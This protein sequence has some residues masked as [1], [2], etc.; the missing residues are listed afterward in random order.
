[1]F[2]S[3]VNEYCDAKDELWTRSSIRPDC[4]KLTTT[5]KGYPLLPRHSS[6]LLRLHF[7]E[8]FTH[9]PRISILIDTC[10]SDALPVCKIAEHRGRTEYIYVTSSAVSLRH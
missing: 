2:H 8:S 1:M 9:F 3:D 10:G 4:S 7:L 6:L 5:P